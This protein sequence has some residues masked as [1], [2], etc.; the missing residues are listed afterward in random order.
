LILKNIKKLEMSY[1]PD[2]LDE[3]YFISQTNK[4]KTPLKLLNSPFGARSGPMQ[5]LNPPAPPSKR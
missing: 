4:L 3:R 2:L 1:R 5:R